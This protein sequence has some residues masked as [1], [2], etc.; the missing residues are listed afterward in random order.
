MEY[1]DGAAA[2]AVHG[3]GYAYACSHIARV[4]RDAFDLPRVYVGQENGPPRFALKLAAYP[5]YAAAR[6]ILARA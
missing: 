1:P 6:R 3:A 4:G 5:C 2:R